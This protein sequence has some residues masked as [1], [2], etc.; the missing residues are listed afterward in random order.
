MPPSLATLPLAGAGRPSPSSHAPLCLEAS[1][2]RLEEDDETVSAPLLFMMPHPRVRVSGCCLRS[3]ATGYCLPLSF[4]TRRCTWFD[5]GFPLMRQSTVLTLFAF[6]F[7]SCSHLFGAVCLWRSTD[8]LILGDDFNSVFAACCDSGY[9]YGVK[10]GGIWT[11]F[12]FSSWKWTP[13]PEVHWSCVHSRCFSWL[14]HFPCEGGTR[15]LLAGVRL[16]ST[17]NLFLSGGVR[18]MCMYSTF[19]RQWIRARASVH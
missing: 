2:F 17:G 1:S 13:G 18:K 7:A 16:R 5:N 6:G 3:S 15:T 14:T 9:V 8:L 11:N 10:S 12:Q 4:R 19:A